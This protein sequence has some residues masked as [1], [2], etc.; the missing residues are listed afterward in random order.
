MGLAEFARELQQADAWRERFR[1]Y[2][3]SKKDFY[4]FLFEL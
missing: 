3:N 4:V 2:A 1:E